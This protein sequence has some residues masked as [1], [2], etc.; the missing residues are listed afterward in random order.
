[1]RTL[2]FP[3]DA[4]TPHLQ[5]FNLARWFHVDLQDLSDL[6]VRLFY[7]HRWSYASAINPRYGNL[8]LSTLSHLPNHGFPWIVDHL[9]DL[10]DHCEGI[11]THRKSLW[12]VVIG[13]NIYA[14][15]IYLINLLLGT[16]FLYINGKPSTATMLD[17]LP[18]WPYYLIYMEL[19]GILVF[20]LLY[21]PFI[22]ND[23]RAK[24]R[25]TSD[26]KF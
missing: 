14:A 1:M 25:K 12:R 18:R 13:L 19:I 10:Y 7:W 11:S 20:L 24:N 26:D 23:W 9:R 3:D 5:P 8:R 17:L 16:D 4:A 2:D 15:I 22:I 6:R 21:L